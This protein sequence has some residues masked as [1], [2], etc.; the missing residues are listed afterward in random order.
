[1]FQLLGGRRSQISQLSFSTNTCPDPASYS[2]KLSQ[3]WK[4]VCCEDEHVSNLTLVVCG[5]TGGGEL[6]V[7]SI[8]PVTEIVR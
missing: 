2:R 1:M 3:I 4:Q 6:G 5:A 8:T 7:I